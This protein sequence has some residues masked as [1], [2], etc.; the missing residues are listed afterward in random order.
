MIKATLLTIAMI[1]A[2]SL[3]APAL[4]ARHVPYPHSVAHANAAPTKYFPG[5]CNRAPRV[6]AFATA[7]W[8]NAPPCEPNSA[9]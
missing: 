4:A 5:G 6:G 8:T 2:S 1:V 7:P 9:F 3:A